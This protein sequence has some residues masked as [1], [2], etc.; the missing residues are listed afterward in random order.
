[1]LEYLGIQR[2]DS[3]TG[4]LHFTDSWMD[5]M[6]TYGKDTGKYPNLDPFRFL[7][8]LAPAM[9]SAV[10]PRPGSGGCPAWERSNRIYGQI[11]EVKPAAA[12]QAMALSSAHYADMIFKAVINGWSM[13][14]TEE[15][16]N[17][18]MRTLRDMD[19]VFEKLDP[20]SR[21]AFMYKS[22]MLLKVRLEVNILSY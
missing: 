1:L 8:P 4:P 9:P 19:Q 11:S 16:N 22:H 18:I 5:K 17:P 13:L 3:S 21:A 10:R 6:A 15:R 2:G 20:V 7:G 12:S 14:N